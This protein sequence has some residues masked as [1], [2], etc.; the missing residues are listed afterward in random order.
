MQEESVTPAEIN[1]F[2]HTRGLSLIRQKNRIE[3]IIQRPQVKIIDLYRNI[4]KI[5]ELIDAIGKV[6]N[7][8]IEEAELLVKYRS[9]IEKE[10]EVADRL[11]KFEDYLLP[12]NLNFHTILSLSYE[13]REKL[14]RI[15]PETIGQASR[16]SGVSP[17]DVSVLIVFLGK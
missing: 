4:E 10:K 5:R 13:A 3:T 12:K 15:K 8:E 11:G 1:P 9:Y 6:R 16:I 17:S 2:L 14:S 7:D